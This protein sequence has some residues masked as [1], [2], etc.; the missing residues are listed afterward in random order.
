MPAQVLLRKLAGSPGSLL[1]A[2]ERMLPFPAVEDATLPPA[3]NPPPDPVRGGATP[4]PDRPP[5]ARVPRSILLGGLGLLAI[6][7]FLAGLIEFRLLERMF[8][9]LEISPESI[10]Q[11]YW[12]FYGGARA[13]WTGVAANPYH[14]DTFAGYVG[15]PS[16]LLWLYPPVLLLLLAPFGAL[17]YGASKVLWVGSALIASIVLARLTLGTFRRS[18]LVA[19]SPLGWASLFI[20]QFSA[21]F[22]L[23]LV[24]ALRFARSRPV[25]AG[26]CIALLT[27]KPQYGLLVIPFLVLTRSWKALRV[28][29]A[30]TLLLILL[31]GMVYGWRIWEWYFQAMIQGAPADYVRQRGSPVRITFLNALAATGLPAPPEWLAYGLLLILAAAGLLRIRDRDAGLK[32]AYV[33]AASSCIAPYFFV[34]D[35]FLLYGGILL[36]VSAGRR[37]AWWHAPVFLA[38]WLSPVVPLFFFVDPVVPAV[39]WPMNV[40]GT[41]AIF[42]LAMREAP[43][44]QTAAIPVTEVPA[45]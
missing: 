10:Q 12:A 6:L 24:V 9:P 44:E 20:G 3:M 36:A 40:L 37:L 31:S 33:L 8:L 38:I 23:L 29:T 34:Y 19:F 16:R 32:V 14:P 15:T 39:L 11:D 18:L 42:R 22:G 17:S 27:V 5:G 45:S 35:Y 1:A 41:L 13:G 4:A 30:F 7:P 21:F 28:A 43:T 2:A 25:L 26:A